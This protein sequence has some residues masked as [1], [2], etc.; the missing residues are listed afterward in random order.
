MYICKRRDETL[1]SF[2][3]FYLFFTLKKLH[4]NRLNKFYYKYINENEKDYF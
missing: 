2:R 3:H 4:H 1:L